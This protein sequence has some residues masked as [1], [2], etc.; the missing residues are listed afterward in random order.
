M[1]RKVAGDRNPADAM[2]KFLSRSLL[3]ERLG[4]LNIDLEWV[5]GSVNRGQG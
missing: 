2:T 4:S 5:F 1:V 3:Q